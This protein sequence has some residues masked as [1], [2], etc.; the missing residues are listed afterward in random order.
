MVLLIKES[1]RQKATG[2]TFEMPFRG[3]WDERFNQPIFGCNNLTS[4]VQYYDGQPFSGNLTMRMDFVEGGVNTFLPVF[5]NVLEATRIQMQN[6]HRAQNNIP[7]VAM[8]ATTP[9]PQQYFPDQNAAFIDPHDPS[10]IFATQPSMGSQQPRTE[11]PSWSVS[12]QNLR[13]R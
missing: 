11:A 12:G 5:N 10:Q 2:E 8:N 3:I 4:T 7:P 9:S 13:R 6:E 1:D